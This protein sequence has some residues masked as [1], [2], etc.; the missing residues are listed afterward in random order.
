MRVIALVLLLGACG[1]GDVLLG[2]D[3]TSEEDQTFVI[4]SPDPATSFRIEQCRLDGDACLPL[5]QLVMTQR[6]VEST[7]GA[8][9]CEVTFDGATTNAKATYTVFNG[10]GNCNV[11]EPGEA[12]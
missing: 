2:K 5:C 4:T 12:F 11:A 9:A 6:N 7:S 1:A 3:C 8:T 10:G